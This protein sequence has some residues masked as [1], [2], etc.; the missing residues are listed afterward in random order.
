MR[1]TRIAAALAGALLLAACTGGGTPTQPSPTEGGAATAGGETSSPGQEGGTTGDGGPGQ[2]GETT[3]TGETPGTTGPATQDG[4]FVIGL[5]YIPDIQFA[6]FYIAESA[7]Y[8]EQEGVQ[9][10]LRHHGA[11]ESLFGALA[12]GDEHVI[13]AGADEMLQSHA[14]GIEVVTTGVLYQEYPAVLIV[15]E[16]S[17]IQTMADIRDHN[18]GLPGPFGENWFALLA[19]MD[20]EGLT[21]A[22]LTISHIGYTQH[23]ALKSG[24][25]DGVVGF[26]NNDLVQFQ[27]AG[28]AVRAIESPD[29]PL[30]GIGIGSMRPLV[31]SNP[32]ALAAINRA[33]SRALT[34]IIADPAAAVEAA[35]ASQPDLAVT[36]NK[37]HALTT[38]EAT[39]P[40]Y[41][42][43]S[44]ALD[45]ADWPTMYEFMVE[46]GIAEAGLDASQAVVAG[47]GN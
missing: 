19:W 33:V 44:L 32:E 3:G 9:V 13:V 45:P 27:R 1:S 38:L 21:E 41:G 20:A 34:D 35:F 28:E 4:P 22:D 31:E 29:L 39:V 14:G 42:D 30:V 25:V 37:E 43:G 16:D 10:T 2:E 46:A 40:L 23:A 15:P 17:E 5:T 26:V 12:A 6:P 36:G 8:F 47:L 24:D 18:I 7:G 11:Q